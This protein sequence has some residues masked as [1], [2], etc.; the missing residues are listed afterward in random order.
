MNEDAVVSCTTSNGAVGADDSVVMTNCWLSFRRTCSLKSICQS[1]V[2]CGDV[3]VPEQSV[4]QGVHLGINVSGGDI[5]RANYVGARRGFV[6]A[7][8]DTCISK[9]MKARRINADVVVTKSQIW[10]GSWKS[11]VNVEDV[12]T[13][14]N[15]VT[16]DGN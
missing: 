15:A 1:K 2:G 7:D 11:E 5:L 16:V 3:P 9:K 12:C 8:H 13:E 4:S 10:R 14:S 6:V